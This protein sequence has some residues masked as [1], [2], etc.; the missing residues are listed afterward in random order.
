[1]LIALDLRHQRPYF[2]VEALGLGLILPR[3][4]LSNLLRPTENLNT[5][6]ILE[7]SRIC[8]KIKLCLPC[9]SSEYQ[10]TQLGLIPCSFQGR[11]ESSIRLN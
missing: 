7:Q 2:Q 8:E 1:M 11:L 3:L 6:T 9:K 5:A 10:G 4:Y